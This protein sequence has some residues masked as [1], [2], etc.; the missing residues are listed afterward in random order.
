LDT[1]ENYLECNSVLFSVLGVVRP[2]CA[3]NLMHPKP[4]HPGKIELYMKLS[5][6]KKRGEERQGKVRRSEARQGNAEVV[7]GLARPGQAKQKQ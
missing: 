7:H 3:L 5:R 1:R 2:D 6:C 4:G